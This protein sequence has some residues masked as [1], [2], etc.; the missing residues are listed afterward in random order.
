MDSRIPIP[1]GHV[2]LAGRRNRQVG[3]QI[4]WRSRILD[5]AIVHPLDAGLGSPAAFAKCQQQFPV[6]RKLAD[7][8]VLIVGAPDFVIWPDR[9]AVRSDEHS[10]AP[11]PDERPIGAEDDHR[12]FAP[13]EDEGSVARIDGDADDFDERPALR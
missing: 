11:R 13:A 12:M 4:E 1:V 2:E 9:N 8:M 5:R 6:G 10:F 3:R 7:G